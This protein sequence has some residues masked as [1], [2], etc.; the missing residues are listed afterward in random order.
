MTEKEQALRPLVLTFYREELMRRYQLDNV[1]RFEP[2][3]T[4][5]DEQ[6]TELRD[7]FLDQ[8]YPPVKR[9]ASLD[10]AF[11]RLSSMLTSP[12]RMRPLVGTAIKSMWRMGTR[13]PSAISAG[14]ST[15][16]AFIKTRELEAHMIK[17]GARRGLSPEQAEDREEML[18]LIQTVPEKMVYRLIDDI[19]DLFRALSN[20]EMLKVALAFMEHCLT[21]MKKHPDLYDEDDLEGVTLGME[22]LRG[23][24]HLFL[25][26]EPSHFKN[27][28][29][30][31]KQV[32]TD[33]F[34]S[35]KAYSANAS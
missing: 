9:R 19:M 34:A 28:I 1:R 17:A 32:E 23:G 14:R 24:L 16:D 35:V 18:K 2:F 33:W 5:S 27:I 13:L 31:I 22:L 12:R 15:V 8:I 7:F 6:I 21:V 10:Q 20:T 11:D 3:E 25:E 29:E 30:G 4:I 26:V